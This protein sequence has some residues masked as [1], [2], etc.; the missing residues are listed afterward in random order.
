[1]VLLL[2]A[3][4][5]VPVVAPV[6]TVPMQ[7]TP[8][9]VYD[10][11]KKEFADLEAMA[12]RLAQADVVFFGEQHDDVGT[13]RMQRAL[14]EALGRRRSDVILSMEMFERDV[15]RVLDQYLG[16]AITEA[17]FTAASR[18]WPKYARDYR[19]LV[20]YARARGWRV[21]AAN[22]PRRMASAVAKDGLPAVAQWTDS[23]RGWAAREFDCPTDDDY[24]RRFEKQMGGHAATGMDAATTAR[25]YYDAQCVKDETMAESIANARSA[26]VGSP[27]IVHIN[28]AFHSDF[29]DGT[30]ERV[31]RRLPKARLM[32]VTGVPVVNLDGIKPK[33]ERKKGEWQVYTLTD[34]KP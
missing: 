28:G 9:R 29:H 23:T 6:D 13:H 11:R 21:V 15:Q 27:L 7:W 12:A 3:L 31:R 17:E 16:G 4:A 32:V 25:R 24:F 5:Q 1:M 34:K 20:E 30:A 10:A 2:L 22:V 18:P 8:H 19:P 14:L 26:A 33:A